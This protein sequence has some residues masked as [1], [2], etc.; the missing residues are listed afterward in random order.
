[1]LKRVELPTIFML[2]LGKCQYFSLP[3]LATEKMEQ[4]NDLGNF[5]WHRKF[6]NTRT[7]E[8]K[9]DD[10]PTAAGD[11]QEWGMLMIKAILSNNHVFLD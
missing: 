5:G 8:A 2:A 11:R 10:T 6:M 9:I 7:L 1:M 3:L 4:E